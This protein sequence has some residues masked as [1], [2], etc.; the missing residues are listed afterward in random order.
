LATSFLSDSSQDSVHSASRSKS[1]A[2]LDSGRDVASNSELKQDTLCYAP[3]RTE[4][5]CMQSRT[6][7]EQN[8]S[9]SSARAK[10]GNGAGYAGTEIYFIGTPPGTGRRSQANGMNPPLSKRGSAWAD[11]VI[12]SAD[13]GAAA[14]RHRDSQAVSRR[15]APA[16][17]HK[18]KAD[19]TGDWPASPRDSLRPREGPP[20][21]SRDRDIFVPGEADIIAELNS[22]RSLAQPF[23]STRGRPPPPASAS[24]SRSQALGSDLHGTRT[25]K[26]PGPCGRSGAPLADLRAAAA[27]LGLSARGQS[28]SHHRASASTLS[29]RRAQSEERRNRSQVSSSLSG[30]HPTEHASHKSACSPSRRTGSHSR[31]PS[32]PA[33]RS[34]S[35]DVPSTASHPSTTQRTPKKQR[36]G[37]QPDPPDIHDAENVQAECEHIPQA[38][39]LHMSRLSPTS[40]APLVRQSS[41]SST[42]CIR[43]PGTST[44]KPSQLRLS[45]STSALADPAS[46]HD[47]RMRLGS[48]R[49]STSLQQ[50]AAPRGG[51]SSVPTPCGAPPWGTSHKTSAGRP[52]P[53][54]PQRGRPTALTPSAGSGSSSGMR[55]PCTPARG[56]PSTG[57]T[58]VADATN[59]MRTCLTQHCPSLTRRLGM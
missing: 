53:V 2:S 35:K 27:A 5:R 19:F 31:S 30:R 7:A 26:A 8:A 44:G 33:P 43:R 55:T 22:L 25:R 3:A 57:Q 49:G 41:S 9:S 59:T 47:R 29:L 46:S 10:R 24:K 39:R 1:P 56:R 32:A 58:K 36:A 12:D 21:S 40:S 17:T 14:C 11:D 23:L 38:V 13:A 4:H 18:A 37:P 52:S 54:T 15:I 45:S 34:S 50:P 16:F 6:V 42:N 48:V 51:S 28:S 20:S